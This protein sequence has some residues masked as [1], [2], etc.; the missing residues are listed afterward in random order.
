[1]SGYWESVADR[2]QGI[3]LE[4]QFETAAYRLVSEQVLYAADSRSRIAYSLVEQFEREFK[5]AL[6]PLGI[7]LVVNRQLRYAC[8]LP[9]H[10]K[11]SVA[12]T[13]QTL[14]ALV[15][16]LIYD[17]S[18]R[19]GQL[20]DEGEVTCDLVEL[21]EKYLRATG[22]LMPAGG[23]LE[24]GMRTMRRWGIVRVSREDLS[25]ASTGVEQPYVV[26][27]RPAIADV[28]GE[29]AL[30]RL[31]LFTNSNDE[32]NATSANDEDEQEEVPS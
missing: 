17:E 11:A 2:T 18:A 28:L 31:A 6:A 15:L 21:D 7:K 23:R 27:I 1:M 25:A 29:S 9:T 26:L 13:D 24:E 20:N 12:T 32:N 8:A 5:P 14:L 4:E 22:R 19:I 30:L 3:Y 10:A 16:R